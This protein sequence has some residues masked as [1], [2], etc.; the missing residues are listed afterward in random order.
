[1]RI[2]D[3]SSDVC[4]SDLLVHRLAERAQALVRG[5]HPDHR[6]EG[7]LVLLRVLA[8][9]LAEGGAVAFDVEQ[10]VADLEGQAERVAEAVDVFGRNCV[11]AGRARA[12]PPRTPQPRAALVRRTA[13]ER[14]DAP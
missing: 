3:W 9:G 1:M 4:S 12:Q 5:L 14:L 2:S 7:G 11:D 8:A 6:G 10:V 13:C